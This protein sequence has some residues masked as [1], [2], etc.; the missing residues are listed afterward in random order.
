MPNS[1]L[2]ATSGNKFILDSAFLYHGTTPQ[3]VLA[4]GGTFDP[5]FD[6]RNPPWANK[7]NPVKGLDRIT[8]Y[9]STITTSFMEFDAAR[10]VELNPGSVSAVLGGTTVVTFPDAGIFLP[11][12]ANVRLVFRLGV[13]YLELRLTAA[14]PKMGAISG[15]DPGEG[16]MP[17]TY[18][19]RADSASPDDCPFLF[20]F[21][22][23]S[24]T[25]ASI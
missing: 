25:L 15:D 3:G 23:D 1:G 2:T 21:H 14:F 4:P 22:P 6:L 16:V 12:I 19:G 8:G 9:I 11:S 10:V 7:T 13:G 17:V 24:T 20:R 5:G 18:E